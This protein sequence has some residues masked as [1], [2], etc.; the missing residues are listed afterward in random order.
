VTDT[1]NVKPG[2]GS[3][4]TGKTLLLGLVCLVAIAAAV[5]MALRS[6]GP[7]EA[8]TPPPIPDYKSRGKVPANVGK[9]PGQLEPG[10]STVPPQT[11]R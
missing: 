1:N 9:A 7:Q 6:F 5:W 10:Q 3:R 11:K 4:D 8:V 2:P